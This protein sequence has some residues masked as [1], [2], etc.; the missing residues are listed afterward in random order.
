MRLGAAATTAG[1]S[2]RTAAHYAR[3]G[4]TVEV[5][6]DPRSGHADALAALAGDIGLVVLPGGSPGGLLDVLTRRPNDVEPTIGERLVAL[7][8]AGTGISGASAGAMVLCAQTATPDR[9]RGVASGLGLVPGLAIPHWSPG[10]ERRW[11]LP[12]ALLWGLPECGGVLIET[13]SM[14]GVGLGAA[15][16]HVDGAWQPVDRE[17]PAPLPR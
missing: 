3:L 13:G 10:S 17:R 2:A 8:R 5:V 4:V 6:S 16:V 15:S 1:A 9:S 11:S 12:E 14:I 7:W